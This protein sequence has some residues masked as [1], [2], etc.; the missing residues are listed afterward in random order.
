LAAE[1]AAEKNKIR[2]FGAPP[3]MTVLSEIERSTICPGQMH[4]AFRIH[5]HA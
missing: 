4:V 2:T 5:Q 3:I 1:K